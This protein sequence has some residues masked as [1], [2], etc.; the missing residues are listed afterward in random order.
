MESSEDRIVAAGVTVRIDFSSVGASYF[1][2]PKLP[3]ASGRA[4]DATDDDRAPR[5]AVINETMAR[6]FW[7]DGT[8]L[9]R[10]FDYRGNRLTIIGI[11]RD[12]KY[13]SLN[14]TTPPFAYFPIAQ[15]WTPTQFLVVRFA[16]NP[17]EL[18]GGIQ[19]A[20]LAI[21]PVLP[22]ATVTSL[23]VADGIALWPQRVAAIV[24]GSLGLT[25]LLLATVGLYGIVSYSVS[26][27]AREIG[28]RV[29]LGA[30]RANVQSMV[31]REGMRLALLGVLIGLSLAAAATRLLA[32]MLFDVS[33]LDPL[34]FG[35]MSLLFIG[36]ALLASW[37]PARRASGTDPMAALRAE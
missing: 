15:L 25:G 30:Q 27:R 37:L 24:T 17:T 2:V 5:V 6:R 23:L 18:T 16:G 7:P 19:R 8:A 1:D 22:R 29:A 12:A 33:A 36:V 32:S 26:R 20:I 21:D 28:I 4:I 14:E 10:T 34:T 31:V 13:A 3:M 11:A 9:G 35:G